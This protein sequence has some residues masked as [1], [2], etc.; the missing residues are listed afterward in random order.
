MTRKHVAHPSRNLGFDYRQ[1]A[2]LIR[3][4]LLAQLPPRLPSPGEQGR[5]FTDDTDQQRDAIQR[6]ARLRTA[7][8]SRTR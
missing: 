2:A 1:A 5:L 4:D 7:R 3:P 6:A 8:R